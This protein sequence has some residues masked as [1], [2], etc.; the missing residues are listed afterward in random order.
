MQEK[1]F[2]I[3]LK[4]TDA[5]NMFESLRVYVTFR[6]A[7]GQDITGCITIDGKSHEVNLM[8]PSL[9]T[10]LASSIK[11]LGI[12]ALDNFTIHPA[13]P[14]AYSV[15]SDTIYDFIKKAVCRD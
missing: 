5:V 14:M 8:P 1:S 3:L 13:L 9:G 11:S 15:P 2:E 12:A 4:S 10:A 6:N 7:R